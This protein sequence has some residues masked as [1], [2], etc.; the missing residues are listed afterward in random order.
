MPRYVYNTMTTVHNTQLFVLKQHV[1]ICLLSPNHDL[2]TIWLMLSPSETTFWYRANLPTNCP[3]NCLIYHVQPCSIGSCLWELWRI[4]KKRNL[5]WTRHVSNAKTCNQQVSKS[6]SYNTPILGKNWI[7]QKQ[8]MTWP[9]PESLIILWNHG[10][11]LHR[12]GFAE[13]ISIK[14][15]IVYIQLPHST[16]FKG[17]DRYLRQGAMGLQKGEFVHNLIY[18]Q[19]SGGSLNYFL[20]NQGETRNL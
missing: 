7:T 9:I 12:E 5:H 18:F 15:I 20:S 13:Q 19:L 1:Q 10:D 8:F 14:F 11:R 4:D 2:K 3:G 6:F 16:T 17:S